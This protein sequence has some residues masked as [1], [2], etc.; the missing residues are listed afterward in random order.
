MHAMPY[1]IKNSAGVWRVQR[2]VPEKLQAAA[3][4]VLG[5]KRQIHPRN[6]GHSL[7]RSRAGDVLLMAVRAE[8]NQP[9]S[10]R[11][12][13]ILGVSQTQTTFLPRYPIELT[14]TGSQSIPS[15][16]RSAGIVAP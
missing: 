15:T 11:V 7:R 2:K 8:D 10:Y 3:A 1:L 6:R 9:R 4:R 12:D 14:P 13:S 16:S 5:N